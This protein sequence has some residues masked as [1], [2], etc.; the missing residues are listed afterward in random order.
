MPVLCSEHVPN[1]NETVQFIWI[2]FSNPFQVR[3]KFRKSVSVYI[4]FTQSIE[5]VVNGLHLIVKNSDDW[6]KRY[7]PIVL[8]RVKMC[9]SAQDDNLTRS[10]FVFC[11]RD[12]C[13]A[14]VLCLTMW[15]VWSNCHTGALFV[16]GKRLGGGSRLVLKQSKVNFRS[17]LLIR[18]WAIATFNHCEPKWI[19]PGKLI[20]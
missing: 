3:L 10:T 14:S 20:L 12:S 19:P 11:D 6:S 5:A 15:V 1:Q 2:G 13:W 9:Y 4:F 18:H 16:S 8:N 17:A 7:R